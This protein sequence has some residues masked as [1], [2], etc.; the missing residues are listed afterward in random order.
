MCFSAPASFISGAALS[1]I[2]VAAIYKARTIPQRI[3]AAIPLIFA[4]QQCCEG[5]LWLS[6]C[7][8]GYEYLYH[9]AMYAFLFLAHA[10]WPAFVP[11]SVL[12]LEKQA[13]R[14]KILMVCSGLGILTALYFCYCLYAYPVTA[15]AESHHIRYVLTFP[16]VLRWLSGLCY[17]L[18]AVCAP[19]ISSIKPVRFFG[20]I[21]L[22]S[23]IIARTLYQD[24]MVSVWCYFAAILS[25]FVLWIVVKIGKDGLK[26][27]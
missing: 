26:A 25:L 21:L 17:I 5:F 8:R 1:V 24:Y 22:V 4:I 20:L 10:L 15:L 7:S 3:F 27:Q 14:K 18:A 11:L 6:F 23:Y 9:P 16:E 13:R 19:F 2:G 12:L